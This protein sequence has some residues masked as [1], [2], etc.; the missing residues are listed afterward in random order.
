MYL[1]HARISLE[2]YLR[3]WSHNLLLKNTNWILGSRY[4]REIYF[5]T[6]AFINKLWNYKSTR[7]DR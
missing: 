7:K 5:L 1:V 4:E 6:C 2:S 3:N